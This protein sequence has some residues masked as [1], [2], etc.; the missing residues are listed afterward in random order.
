MPKRSHNETI[1]AAFTKQCRRGVAC[2]QL[3]E[4]V[5]SMKRCDENAINSRKWCEAL[6]L[7][8]L[9]RPVTTFHGYAWPHQ[10]STDTFIKNWP[11]YFLSFQYCSQYLFGYI[12]WLLMRVTH[13]LTIFIC[14]W[15]ILFYFILS[16]VGLLSSN[17]SLK[18]SLSLS[19]YLMWFVCRRACTLQV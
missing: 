16:T 10:Y 1:L 15:Q 4:L 17:F 18:L 14:R 13:T 6:F 19:F 7:F 3:C 5:G 11:F 9:T 8:G 12:L 2:G